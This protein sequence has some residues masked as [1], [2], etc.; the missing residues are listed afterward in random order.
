MMELK[1]GD[2]VCLKSGGPIMTVESARGEYIDC[3]FFHGGEMYKK[4]LDVAVLD[5]VYKDEADQWVVDNEV[6]L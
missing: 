3:I 2:T 4:T 1:A 5:K 6:S